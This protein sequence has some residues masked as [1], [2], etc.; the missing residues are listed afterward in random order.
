MML[1]IVEAVLWLIRFFFGA[2]VF[3]F[4]NVMI[5]R[6]PR[7]ES[8]A[9]GRSHCTACGRIL[10]P[11]EL[12]PCISF[13]C[14]RGRCRG[15]GA[16]IPV[17]DFVVELFG[18]AAFMLCSVR[19]GCGSLGVISLNGAVI[20]LYLGILVVVSLIDWDTQIIYDRFHIFIVIL[21]VAHLWLF[22]QHGILDRLLGMVVISVPMLV[23]SLVI[24]GAFGGGDIK[25]MAASGLFLGSAPIVCAMFFGL[26]TGGGYAAYMLVTGKLDRKAQFAFGPFLS[27]GLMIA[28]LAGDQIMSWY[29][30]LLFL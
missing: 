14:L 16:Q 10:T 22:P 13:L 3:S 29:L 24:P 27:V 18:G 11:L 1:T 4:L 9:G 5:D 20:F 7:G 6:I 25:L 2:C 30:G 21:A 12:I 8:V 19:Y 26:L 28:A 15:C 17:R 23:L